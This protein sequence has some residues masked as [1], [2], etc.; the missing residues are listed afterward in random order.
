M[1]LETPPRPR[2]IS[3][4]A[5]HDAR[6]SLSPLEAGILPFNLARLFFI[7]DVPPGARRGGHHAACDQFLFATAGA[8]VVAVAGGAGARENFILEA[9]KAGLFVPKGMWLELSGF[10]DNAVIAVA[11]SERY[12]APAH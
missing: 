1:S 3:V 11:C 7:R 5:F 9:W 2:M 8:C 10:R 6:G 4:P 12:E